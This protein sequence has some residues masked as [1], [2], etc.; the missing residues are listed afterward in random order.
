M[1]NIQKK[2]IKPDIE[3]KEFSHSLMYQIHQMTFMTERLL[4]KKLSDKSP[5]S[6]S[7]F[8]IIMGINCH[9]LEGTSQSRLAE[10]LHMTEATISRHIKSLEKS[11]LLLK[12]PSLVHKKLKLLSLSPDGKLAFT[13]TEQIIKRELDAIFG[14]LTNSDKKDLS[15]YFDRLLT[16]LLARK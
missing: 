1:V 14:T 4:E 9:Q 15:K 2:L 7:Q 11:G 13:K 12:A 3:D 8:V 6:F 5:L 16:S 10:F